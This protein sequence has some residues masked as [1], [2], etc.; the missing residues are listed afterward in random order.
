MFNK[1]SI[2]IILVWVNA[3][4]S[5]SNQIR[6]SIPTEK[7][8]SLD[9]EFYN[10]YTMRDS[11]F[12]FYLLADLLGFIPSYSFTNFWSTK[13]FLDHSFRIWPYKKIEM[14]SNKTPTELV[15]SF[16]VK[17]I[18]QS[19]YSEKSNSII[20]A[21]GIY[22]RSTFLRVITDKIGIKSFVEINQSTSEIA[23][24]N[25]YFE[26]NRAFFNSN[27]IGLFWENVTPVQFNDYHNLTKFG[28]IFG[29]L[30]YTYSNENISSTWRVGFRSIDATY[31]YPFIS[32][33]FKALW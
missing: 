9:Y 26:T 30:L 32:Y 28:D 12:N 6:S 23:Q 8:F 16:G 2:G 10:E 25:F 13:L 22:I 3:F 20:Y 14:L 31:N 15:I 17:A 24:W 21:P 4:S 27:R 7:K 29:V 11:E 5:N 18:K 1:I 19:N 33:N